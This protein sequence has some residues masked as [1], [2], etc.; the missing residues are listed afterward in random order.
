MSPDLILYPPIER[1]GVIGDRRT[2]GLVAADGT[3]AWLCLPNYE[4]PSV[5][6]AQLDAQRGGF[7]RMGPASLRLG[8]Q[9]YMEDT[10]AAQRYVEWL[11]TLDSSTDAPFQPVYGIDGRTELSQ[12]ERKDLS[13]YRGSRPVRVGNHA[14]HMH[15]PDSLGFLANCMWIYL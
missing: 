4:G 2:A 9:H 11:T 3:L 13:G 5:F 7:W 8:Q 15:Q 12:R 1:H 14:F 6:S 10:K